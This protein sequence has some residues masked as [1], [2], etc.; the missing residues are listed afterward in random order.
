LLVFGISLNAQQLPGKSAFS[1]TDFIW[2][3]ALTAAWDYWELSVGH[4]QEWVGF[5]GAPST[6]SAAIQFPFINHNMSI[7][8]FFM[9]DRIEPLLSNS[10]S[11]S[12][13]YKIRL[14][15]RQ[16][17]YLNF[18]LS[19][20]LSHY[21]I[22][23]KD[24]VVNDEDD[25]LLPAGENDN[26]SPNIGLGFFY[27]TN[28]EQA[29][30]SQFFFGLAMTQLFGMDVV[31][32]DFGG[33]ANFQRTWHG[34]ALIG[35]RIANDFHFLEPMLWI[36][37]SEPGIKNYYFGIKYEKYRTFWAGLNFSTNQTLAMQAGFIIHKRLPEFTS[38][39]IGTQASFNVGPFGKYRGIGYEFYFAYRYFL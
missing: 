14:S 10:L 13:A 2:N 15:K 35:G 37:F 19:A 3:P 39:R 8:G 27:T 25:E 30:E 20:S 22:D 7:G 12:Y 4:R 17:H 33:P 24:L 1:E 21:H 6:S 18:G 28:G 31:L 26:F 38:F 16:A 34:N 11:L 36:N 23:I 29:E 9:T 32:E 5:E